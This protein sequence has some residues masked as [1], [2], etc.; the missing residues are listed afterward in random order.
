MY[1]TTLNTTGDAL[2]QASPELVRELWTGIADMFAD[3]E[4]A[5]RNMEGGPESIIEAV[6]DTT[7]GAGMKVT[8]PFAQQFYGRP[9]LGGNRF[10]TATK[11]DKFKMWSNELEVDWIRFGANYDAR[12][13]E[14]MGMINE[15]T[16][17][18]PELQGAQWGRYK[19]EMTQMVILHKTNPENTW[20]AGG[21][22][23]VHDL[24]STD[25]LKY[26]EIVAMGAFLEPL[27]GRPAYVGKD[28]SGNNIYG[29]CVVAT[30]P[31]AHGLDNDQVYQGFLKEAAERGR[32]NVLF[33]GGL[34]H[35]KGHVIKKH[36]PIDRD[37]A[38]PVGSILQPKAL[39]GTAISPGTGALTITGGGNSTNAALSQILY[40]IAFP[41]YAYTFLLSD[42]LSTTANFWELGTGGASSGNY[43]VTIVNPR[44]STL[45]ADS[46]K[47]CIYEISANDGNQLT[48]AKRLG[49]TVAGIQNST[50]GAVTWSSSLHTQTH[51]S[52]A[53]VYL[54]N[55]SGVPLMASPMLS[56][57]C[58]RR[59]YGRYN[60][61]RAVDSDEAG[62]GKYTYL[63]NV[64][65]MG[66][67][68][69]AGGRVTGIAI[70]KHTG[71][72]E[73]WNVPQRTS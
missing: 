63:W 54:S 1:L 73:G 2:A 68:S 57:S 12:A 44:S 13:E 4:D 16:D 62:F 6:K 37:E 60:N 45:G 17:R 70:L 10:D 65:G 48:V 8:F 5:F 52:G 35:I 9:Q 26:D 7:K 36:V 42:I 61:Y 18:F 40:F 66:L 55:A 28:Q 46:G 14:K 59:G 69:N 41:K 47:F 32:G 22:T 30:A 27:G 15:I 64:M 11:Y 24:L 58:I 33:E 56:R 71:P 38:G 25:T 3:E 21:R 29:R 19:S 53:L 51:P 34:E 49:P 67:K 72:I 23:S 39:L 50:V 31:A 43:F 20:L